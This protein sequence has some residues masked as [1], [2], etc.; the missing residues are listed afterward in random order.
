MRILL[1]VALLLPAIA[2]KKDKETKP[3]IPDGTYAGTFQRQGNGTGQVVNVTLNLNDFGFN[4]SGPAPANRY[5]VI[6][7]G[8]YAIDNNKITF[9][10]SLVYTADFDWTL[11]LSQEYQFDSRGDSLIIVRQYNAQVRDIYKLKKHH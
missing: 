9:S 8:K 5:P 11:I 6:G 7:K 1:L 4:S 10:D 3:V 2:C